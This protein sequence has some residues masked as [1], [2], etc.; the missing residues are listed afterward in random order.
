MA[1][2]VRRLR[3][4]QP[5]QPSPAPPQGCLGNPAS[6]AIGWPTSRMASAGAQVPSCSFRRGCDLRC[7]FLYQRGRPRANRS[8]RRRR[9]SA[10]P[11]HCQPRPRRDGRHG[12]HWRSTGR[13]E[14]VGRW[15]AFCRGAAERRVEL[16]L[17]DREVRKSRKHWHGNGGAS[18]GS[19]RSNR[20]ELR[21]TLGRTVDCYS[22]QCVGG[23]HPAPLQRGCLYG[24]ALGMANK[25]GGLRANFHINLPT[26]LNWCK[27]C[28]D[29]NTAR[30][31][32]SD[33]YCHCY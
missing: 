27:S 1:T 20:R 18:G 16:N 15:R 6:N 24:V 13:V 29:Y 33:C 2:V 14:V 22:R 12:E 31:C 25:T 5:C 21:R 23:A 7:A 4:R 32:Y 28:A 17:L 10:H 26:P 8:H 9:H 11:R 19:D 3:C 30:C